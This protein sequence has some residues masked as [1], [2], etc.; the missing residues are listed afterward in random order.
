[1]ARNY[2]LFRIF[3]MTASG[4]KREERNRKKNYEYL[5]NLAQQMEEADVTPVDR[6]RYTAT[7]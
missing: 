7:V 3:L 2:C 1:M 4:S 6:M 5:R